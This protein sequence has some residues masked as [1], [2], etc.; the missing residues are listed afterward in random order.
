MG[1][2]PNDHPAPTET[3]VSLAGFLERKYKPVA[4]VHEHLEIDENNRIVL[5]TDCNK[6]V[7]PF[8]AI[9]QLAK[10][11]SEWQSRWRAM[12]ED[13]KNLAGWVP[14]LRA[15]RTLEGMWRG[16]RLPMCPHCKKG[17][18]AEGLNRLGWVHQRYAEAVA[19]HE[20]ETADAGEV[21]SLRPT[22]APESDPA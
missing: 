5:C 19:E 8:T 2:E 12:R 17:V 18:T 3:I 7:D 1:N 10:R 4:C 14:H 11:T 13:W 15:V 9:C 20:R 6:E 21:V 22:T 16:N